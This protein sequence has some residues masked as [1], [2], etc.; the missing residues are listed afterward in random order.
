MI[1]FEEGTHSFVIRIW[2]ERRE[3]K[4]VKPLW[5]GVIEHVPSGEQYPVKELDEIIVFIAVYLEEMGVKFEGRSAFR[6]WLEKQGWSRNR[7]DNG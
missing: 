3:S 4:G 7:R 1:S 6:R 5:R 2:R